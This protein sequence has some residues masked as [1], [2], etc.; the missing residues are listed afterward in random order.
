[1]VE[2]KILT[3]ER[4]AMQN[5]LNSL[6]N[7]I[8]VIRGELV[9]LQCRAGNISSPNSGITLYS[10]MADVASI[11]PHDLNA[12]SWLVTLSGQN[13]GCLSAQLTSLYVNGFMYTPSQTY[14]LDA[15]VN[16]STSSIF[17]KT[18]SLLVP[19]AAAF[20]L[21]FMI[22]ADSGFVSGG[23]LSGTPLLY[24]GQTINLQVKTAGGDYATISL[25]LP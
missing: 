2:L 13:T 10:A 11:N 8:A 22:P 18:Y 21:A 16:G 5:Q 7:Q 23:P 24:S 9:L 14:F 19:S 25:V 15:N 17:T 4:G 3:A 12:S 1:M 6:S 20:Q